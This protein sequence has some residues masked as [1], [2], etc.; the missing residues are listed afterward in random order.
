MPKI[1]QLRVK[2]YNRFFPGPFTDNIQVD[3]IGDRDQCVH[4][5]GSG[6]DRCKGMGSTL[7]S[8]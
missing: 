4:F 1:Q 8:L 2:I 7:T 6:L 3:K 5:T